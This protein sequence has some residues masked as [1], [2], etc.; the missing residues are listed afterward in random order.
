M[1]AA[2]VPLHYL[3]NFKSTGFTAAVEQGIAD[4]RVWCR[5]HGVPLRMPAAELLE[6]TFDET[7][8]GGFALGA[9]EPE[10]GQK[11]GAAAGTMMKMNAS[12]AIHDLDRFL[13]VPEHAGALTGTVDFSPIGNGMAA[14]TGV[15]NLL[16]PGNTPDLKLFI[17]ELGFE[18]AGK[19]YYLA[20]RKLVHEGGN[21]LRETTTLYTR[22]YEGRAA[23]SP[24]VGAGVLTL[25]V[26]DIIRL[27]GTIRVHNARSVRDEVAGLERFGK[28]FLGELWV[29]YGIHLHKLT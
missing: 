21:A 9:T 15:F 16:K 25:E 19:D 23:N 22:L 24:V 11:R 10:D 2:E 6:L 18:H 7:M 12:I 28:F 26:E 27:L 13:N 20:G 4:A 29:S 1:L 14:T 5:Q 3:I 8:T 17:Y